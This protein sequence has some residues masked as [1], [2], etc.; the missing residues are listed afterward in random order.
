MDISSVSTCSVSAVKSQSVVSGLVGVVLPMDALE[1]ERNDR[2]PK[3]SRL[4]YPAVVELI[5]SLL[6]LAMLAEWPA[7]CSTSPIRQGDLLPTW[8]IIVDV[9]DIRVALVG[10]VIWINTHF[11]TLPSWSRI[12]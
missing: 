1:V 12:S 6:I 9:M 8:A 4:R 10:R 11:G 5:N 3:I 7:I 2:V